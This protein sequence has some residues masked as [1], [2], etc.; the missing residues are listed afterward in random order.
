M[1]S[2]LLNCKSDVMETL[3][4]MKKYNFSSEGT[5]FFNCF[6]TQLLSQKKEYFFPYPFCPFLHPNLTRHLVG[7]QKLGT[8][9]RFPFFF[10]SF[11][12]FTPK[13]FS[14]HIF[15]TFLSE[16]A[17]L[18]SKFLTLVTPVVFLTVPHLLQ[19]LTL[20]RSPTPRDAF[21]SFSISPSH[22]FQLPDFTQISYAS[23]VCLSLPL[24]FFPI[25]KASRSLAVPDI[26]FS[27]PDFTSI[28]F[29]VCC[30]C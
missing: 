8:D 25:A 14:C 24:L 3:N 5:A 29:F 11:S 2:N 6:I 18:P 12:S 26:G 15:F 23:N 13:F 21:S 1:I 17:Y 9:F 22:Q 7:T 16:I 19:N 27:L 28:G 10:S 4:K 20:I 30:C